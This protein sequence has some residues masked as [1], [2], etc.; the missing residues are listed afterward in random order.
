MENK[1]IYGFFGIPSYDFIIYLASILTNLGMRVLVIDH[2]K[3]QDVMSCYVAPEDRIDFFQYKDVDYASDVKPSSI[4]TLEY[5]YIFLYLDEPIR[6]DI[7]Y[8]GIFVISDFDK[9]NLKK[10]GEYVRQNNGKVQ[11]IIR[12]FC[13]EKLNKQYIFRECLGMDASA[14]DYNVIELDYYDYSY[15]VSMTHEYYQGFRHISKNYKQCLLKIIE[16]MANPAGKTL[17]RAYR[18]AERGKCNGSSFLE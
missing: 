6:E 2:S 8:D 4:D 17:Y 7:N 10:A 9:N 15:R 12:D 14:L 3:K 5:Q 1:K 18:W 16:W 13:D 11:F